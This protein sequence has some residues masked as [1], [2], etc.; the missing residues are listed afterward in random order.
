MEWL[1]KMVDLFANL[2]DW[3]A[4]AATVMAPDPVYVMIFFGPPVLTL[5]MVL[6]MVGW[7]AFL[8]KRLEREI[9]RELAMIKKP[10]PK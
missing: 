8:R 7:A 5:V 10:M 9:C 4:I 1:T 3:Q 2:A 6:M